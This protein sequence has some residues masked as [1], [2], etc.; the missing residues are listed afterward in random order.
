MAEVDV[1]VTLQVAH[2]AASMGN[3]HTP[4]SCIPAWGNLASN[5]SDIYCTTQS[6]CQAELTCINETIQIIHSTL[7]L[8]SKNM[9]SIS[10]LTQ[11]ESCAVNEYQ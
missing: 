7:R 3:I 2:A 8:N 10:K 4:V 11:V 5:M 6:A 1:C 9:F